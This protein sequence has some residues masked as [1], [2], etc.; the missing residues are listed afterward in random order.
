MSDI[1]IAFDTVLELYSGRPGDQVD[2]EYGGW[3]LEQ[4]ERLSDDDWH[5]HWKVVLSREDKFYVRRY[6]RGRFKW[7]LTDVIRADGRYPEAIWFTEVQPHR[8]MVE[9][10]EYLTSGE[11]DAR[12]TDL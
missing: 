12:S 2:E 4:T 6:Y 10:T 9:V 5:S 1:K 8:R 3:R 11:S 7:G